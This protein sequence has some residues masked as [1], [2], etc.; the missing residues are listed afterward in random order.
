[1]NNE[2]FKLQKVWQSLNKDLAEEITTFWMNNKALPSQ[3]ATM[4]RAGQV[5]YVARSSSGQIIAVTTAYPQYN[6]Q[7]NN[8]FYYIR[9]FV[10]DTSRRS[11][12][13]VELLRKVR[14]LFESLYRE[15]V[16]SPAIGLFMEVENPLLKQARNEAVWPT[17]GFVYIGDNA[18]G[19]HQRV[20][21]FDGARIN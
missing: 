19:D 17:T 16:I 15:G 3:K 14:S 9:A 18:K 13:G 5:A 7:L 1:M 8:H 6:E 11:H 20:Y 4:S 12:L 2:Q 10:A 21:Y